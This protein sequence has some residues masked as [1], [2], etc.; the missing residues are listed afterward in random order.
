MLTQSTFYSCFRKQGFV[1]HV[2]R[3]QKREIE[4]I[5]IPGANAPEDFTA[6]WFNEFVDFDSGEQPSGVMTDQEICAEISGQVLLA[7]H[8]E[9]EPEI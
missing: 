8:G 1:S 6:H 2:L 9:Q 4:E 7:D 5:N 3:Q